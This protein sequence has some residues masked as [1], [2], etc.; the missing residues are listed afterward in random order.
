M[1][2]DYLKEELDGKK[3]IATV[4]VLYFFVLSNQLKKYTDIRN[5]KVTSKIY[6]RHIE[7]FEYIKLL[8]L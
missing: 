2:K 6:D 1:S 8:D 7:D 5:Y 4:R 3:F